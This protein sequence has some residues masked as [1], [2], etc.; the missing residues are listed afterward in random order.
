MSIFWDLRGV[1][2]MRRKSTGTVWLTVRL[3]L[4]LDASFGQLLD[5]RG[6]EA[7]DQGGIMA[8]VAGHDGKERR[9]KR[10]RE[11]EGKRGWGRSWMVCCLAV[12]W[13]CVVIPERMCVGLSMDVSASRDVS[14]SHEVNS[15]IRDWRRS[16]PF[17][18]VYVLYLAFNFA[19][20]GQAPRSRSLGPRFLTE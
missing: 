20:T 16:L 12:G 18:H 15:V 8:G 11:R 9:R 2:R 1:E 10:K 7:V 6:R 4:G 19:F 14:P 3:R 5:L 17:G 13:I